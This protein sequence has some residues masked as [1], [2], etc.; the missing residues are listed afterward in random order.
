MLLSDSAG[1]GAG[2]DGFQNVFIFVSSLSKEVSQV[3][4]NP[5][6]FDYRIPKYGHADVLTLSI[7]CS[8]SSQ[9]LWAASVPT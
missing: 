2:V 1:L 3:H 6:H 7:I 9:A 5:L 8:P 4:L